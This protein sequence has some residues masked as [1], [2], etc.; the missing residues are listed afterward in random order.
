MTSKNSKGQSIDQWK[1]RLIKRGKDDNLVVF[2]NLNA[3]EIWPYKRV[4]F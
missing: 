2:Y 1:G 4:A 3:S